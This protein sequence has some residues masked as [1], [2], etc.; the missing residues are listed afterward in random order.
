MISLLKILFSF[1][2]KCNH[3]DIQRI[4]QFVLN[5]SSSRSLWASIAFQN[6]KL[7]FHTPGCLWAFSKKKRENKNYFKLKGFHPWLIMSRWKILTT[8][9]VSVSW[10]IFIYEFSNSQVNIR[11]RILNL[12]LRKIWIIFLNQ[13]LV[14]LARVLNWRFR[15]RIAKL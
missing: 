15:R 7:L 6:E 11:P 13:M 4:R 1:S 3:N 12:Q 2:A 14:L 9:D 8:P 5:L 10:I